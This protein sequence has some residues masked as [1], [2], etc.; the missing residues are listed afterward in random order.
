MKTCMVYDVEVKVGDMVA[1]NDGTEHW[2]KIVA[3]S[4]VRG[5]A[6]LLLETG[7]GNLIP[8][9]ADACWAD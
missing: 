4:M 6:E 8:R 9:L 2:A 1:F 7:D 5:R 3:I